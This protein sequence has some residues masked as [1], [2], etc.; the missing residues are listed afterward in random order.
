[1]KERRLSFAAMAM[2]VA[3]VAATGPSQAHEAPRLVEYLPGAAQIPGEAE[4]A[5]AEFSSLPSEARESETLE[6]LRDDPSVAELQVGM[7]NPEAVRNARAL[8][9]ALPGSASAGPAEVISFGALEISERSERDYSVYGRNA[10][11]Q[12]EV[13]LVVMDEDLV[14]TVTHDGETWDLRPLGG[15][16]TAVYR[17]DHSRFPPNTECGVSS[18]PLTPVPPGPGN[19]P[20]HGTGIGTGGDDYRRPPDVGASVAP[21]DSGEVIDVLV[22]YTPA[23][24][25]RAGNIDALI[26]LYFGDTNRFFAN[27]LILPRVRLVHSYEVDYR[28]A[29][30]GLRADHGRLQAPDDGYLDE[31]H[32]MRNRHG[33]DL[34]A[35]LVGRRIKNCGIA[36]IYYGREDGG[37]SVTAQE[38]SSYTFAHELGHNLGAHHDPGTNV[39]NEVVLGFPYGQGLCNSRGRWRTVMSYNYRERCRPHVPHFSNPNISYRGTPTGDE[40]ARHNV[41]VI[42]ETAF[43]VAN[44]RTTLP[45]RHS[46]PLVMSAD[47]GNRQGFL[48]ITNRSRRSGTVRIDAFDDDGR[49]FGPAYLSLDARETRH[50]NSEDLER[51]N[52]SKGLSNGVGN[53]SGDWR[54]DL[55]TDLDIRTR[56]YVR[57]S[58]GFLTSI[59]EVA[60]EG[61]EGSMR[62]RVPTF[63]PGKNAD[64]ESRLRLIN[65]GDGPARATISG[66]DDQGEPASGGSVRLTLPA[67]AAKM[68]SARE[69]ERGARGISGRLEAGK[70]KW[71][72]SVSSDQPLQ[73]MSLLFSRRTGNLTNLSR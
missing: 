25:T 9:L 38:C 22:A 66:R 71:Q 18:E 41:R 51:G 12:S 44:F 5:K 63:N 24:R 69:L 39:L 54:L 40:H 14:G 28:Q 32:A 36:N 65:V 33:A 6:A 42:N 52:A 68:L 30:D 21:A 10:T 49:P 34:V 48:R 13:S 26:R 46:I 4:G 23:A 27:S 67:G 16:L 61:D 50:F 45:P 58:D 2:I 1:M 72:L 35:L 7:A 29:G 53:G 56:A 37:F 19:A 62:Y 31:I 8:S 55:T 47:N 60:A 57:T 59:H 73:V 70:G 11:S 17:R 64:Q 3:T 15:G 43:H 20:K